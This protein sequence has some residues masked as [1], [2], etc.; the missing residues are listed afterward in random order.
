MFRH[1]PATDRQYEAGAMTTPLLEE[2]IER[3]L[4]EIRDELTKMGRLVVQALKDA[5]QAL[6][7]RD[8][9]LAYHVILGDNRIDAL[10]GHVDRLCQEFL[11][12]H[13]PVAG[14][15]RFVIAATK[16]NSELERMGDY[17]DAIARRT[18]RLVPVQALP[19]AERM[20]EMAALAISMVEEATAAFVDED[21]ERAQRALDQETAV[22]A[23]NHD[24]FH[25]LA[26]VEREETDLTTRFVLLG[27]LNRLERV[28]DRACN[29]AEDSIY[30]VRGEVVRHMP[31]QEQKVLL[32]S[33]HD[34]TLGPMAEAMAQK[35]APLLYSFTSAGLEPSEIDTRMVAFMAQRGIEIARNRSR[36]LEEVGGIREFHVVVLLSRQAE[37]ACPQLPYK[38]VALTWDLPDPSLVEGTP[39]QVESAYARAYAEIDT[40]L[41]DLL[42]A[43]LGD[44]P[45]SRSRK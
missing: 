38:T 33:K 11:I 19:I 43:L 5:I 40:K 20:F 7:S 45:E 24:L 27:V 34:S 13:M 22:D 21:P 36:S 31:R 23:L 15:L 12:R 18:V 14:Q 37:E 10:E 30:S 42:H 44:N 39:A 16:V 35:R 4:Q 3:D 17:A 1:R 2:V 25:E 29:I 6:Q 32:L 9:R 26:H 41:G 28:A 8:R